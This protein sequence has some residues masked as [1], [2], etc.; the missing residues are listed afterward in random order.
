MSAASRSSSA[1]R[2]LSETV[3]MSVDPYGEKQRLAESYDDRVRS[4]NNSAPRPPP[5][6]SET[7]R[8]SIP[9]DDIIDAMGVLSSESRR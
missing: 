8:G 2:G 6:P 1:A 3:R 4:R 5:P 7:V 9:F